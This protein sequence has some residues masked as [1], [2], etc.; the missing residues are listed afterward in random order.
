MKRIREKLEK[1]TIK[2]TSAPEPAVT[3]TPDPT[4]ALAS[5]APPEQHQH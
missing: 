5:T 3:S 2:P 4:P 1:P